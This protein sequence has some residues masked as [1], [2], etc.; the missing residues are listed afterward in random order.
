MENLPHVFRA[1]SPLSFHSSSTIQNILGNIFLTYLLPPQNPPNQNPPNFPEKRANY[2][3]R[4]LAAFDEKFTPFRRFVIWN[5]GGFFLEIS[6][7]AENAQN[8]VPACV[9][10]LCRLVEDYKDSE[11]LFL[12]FRNILWLILKSLQCVTVKVTPF[13]LSYPPLPFPSP[14]CE[15]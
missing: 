7:P 8:L 1:L 5:V 10:V 6:S 13:P 14:L 4:A 2:V 3:A 12:D 15:Y 11:T 9:R